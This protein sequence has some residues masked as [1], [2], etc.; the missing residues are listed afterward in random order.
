MGVL[1]E[2]RCNTTDVERKKQR[3]KEV[4]EELKKEREDERERK[5]LQK[6]ELKDL[7]IRL[8]KTYN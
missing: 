7:K 5:R 6:E 2:K 4:K 3:E 1:N 8:E